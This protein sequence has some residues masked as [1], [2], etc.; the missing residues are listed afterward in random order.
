MSNLNYAY[1]NYRYTIVE[2]ETIFNKELISK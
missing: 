1:F 2:T